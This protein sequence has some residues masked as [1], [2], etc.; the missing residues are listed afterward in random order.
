MRRRWAACITAPIPTRPPILAAR[1][2]PACRSSPGR[3][4]RRRRHLPDPHLSPINVFVTDNCS[5]TNITCNKVDQANGC[6]HTRTL[7]YPAYVKYATSREI[8]PL[9]PHE[10]LPTP[11]FTN[12]PANV[13]LG[14]NPQ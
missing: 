11:A 8:Y 1:A 9:S 13:N 3:W 5:V 12:C 10:A 14:T 4:T 7:V 6:F 2:A